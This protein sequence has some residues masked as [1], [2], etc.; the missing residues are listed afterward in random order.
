[1]NIAPTSEIAY[2]IELLRALGSDDAA[3]AEAAAR[4]TIENGVD[5]RMFAF[6][7]AVQYL[8]R[9]AIAND[10]IEKELA[11]LDEQVPALL[12]VDAETVPGKFRMAQGMAVDAWYVSLPDDELQRRVDVLLEAG[13][14]MGFEPARSIVDNARPHVARAVVVKMDVGISLVTSTVEMMQES[15]SGRMMA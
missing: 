1:M 15:I 7:G 11:W 14:A 13:R 4:R 9:A 8:L 5:E 10:S 2:R 3:A 12:D 6:G